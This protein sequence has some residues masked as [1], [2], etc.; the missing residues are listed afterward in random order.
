MRQAC[1]SDIVRISNI[2]WPC[3]E[4]NRNSKRTLGVSKLLHKTGGDF[5]FS[6]GILLS[7]ERE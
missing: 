6:Q 2:G 5:F 4:P 1:Q 7:F 3:S